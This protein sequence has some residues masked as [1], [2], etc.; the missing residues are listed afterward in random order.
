M[1]ESVIQTKIKKKLEADG[2]MVIKLIKTSVN[3]IPDLM[4]LKNGVCHFIEVK[5]TKGVLSEIQKYRIDQLR[6]IG[7][8]ADVWTDYKVNYER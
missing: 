4:A 2:W 7:F 3:G 6:S 5:Q 1:L 8:Q